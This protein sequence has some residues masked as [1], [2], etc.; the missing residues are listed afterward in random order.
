MERFTAR[1][2]RTGMPEIRHLAALP[3][4]HPPVLLVLIDAEE[5]FDWDGG[6][7]PRA[8]S[9]SA[10]ARLERGQAVLDAFGIRPLY[11]VSYPVASQ[12]EGFEPLAGI[13]ADGRCEIGAHLHPWVTPPHHADEGAEESFPGNLAPER[14]AA[15]LTALGDAIEAGTGVRPRVYQAGRYGFGP[16]TAAILAEQG[17]EVDLSIAPPFDYRDEGGPDFSH[18]PVDPFWFGSDQQLLGVPITGAYLGW[19]AAVGPGLHRLAT[20]PWLERFRV[21]GVLS[22]L[23]ALE[24]LRLSPEGFELHDLFRLTRCLLAR[25]VRVVTFSWHAPSLLP[26]CTPYV[27]DEGDVDRFLDRCRAYFDFFFGELGGVTMTP[28]ELR[29]HLLQ[30][31]LPPRPGPA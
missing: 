21:P 31:G 10:M 29:A 12:A 25:G 28:L 17:F 14:E 16:S 30:G 5:E 15:K 9:V 11:A 6:F 8:T 1:C 23:G 24:R 3:E 13:V 4:D 22:R 2:T 26:G 18:G 20:R 27:H 19:A 7:D